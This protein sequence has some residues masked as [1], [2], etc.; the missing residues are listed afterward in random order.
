MQTLTTLNK[1][2]HIIV[3]IGNKRAVIDTGS[4][5]S[6]SPEPFDFLGDKH[7][8]P[9]TIMGVTPGK[10]SELAGFQIDILIGC[11]ILSKYTLRLRWR[12]D[13]LDEGDDIPDGPLLSK[14]ETLMGIPVFPLVLAGRSTKALFDTGA[15][16][17]YIDPGLVHGQTPSGER[18]DFYPFVGHFKAPTFVVATALDPTP[19]DIE[20]GILPNSLQM[21]LGMAMTM[22]DSSA[23][24]GTQILE[25]F[26]CTISWKRETISW[27]R[28]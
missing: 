4:P 20:Y 28:R 13:L 8:P 16:L 21:M 24:V 11:D 15:H 17:S 1:R 6:M 12:D 27:R 3:P 22:S 2:G 25:S 19:M 10:M 26:D 9:A 5:T 14:L 7:S 23:V 18:D